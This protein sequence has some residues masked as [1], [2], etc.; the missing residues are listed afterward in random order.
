MNRISKEL[1]KIAREINASV[2]SNYYD[3][4]IQKR[5]SALIETFQD[6]LTYGQPTKISGDFKIS[7]IYYILTD[8]LNIIEDKIWI[9]KSTSDKYHNIIQKMEPI[10]DYNWA[11]FK[12]KMS[13]KEQEY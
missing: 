1:L 13:K 5:K 9:N 3:K 8:S 10:N 4:K 12:L 2:L 11:N 6:I 7:Q